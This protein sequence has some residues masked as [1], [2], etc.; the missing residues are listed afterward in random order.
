MY[1]DNT[2]C[3]GNPSRCIPRGIQ[4]VRIFYHV[5]IRIVYISPPGVELRV[6]FLYFVYFV[7]VF[8]LFIDDTYCV[9]NAFPHYTLGNT[10]WLPV[11]RPEIVESKQHKT[12]KIHTQNT[13]KL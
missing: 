8:V 10:C 7:H 6:L 1:I 9:H 4:G 3:V 2:D 5:R 12:R 13:Q 11:Q